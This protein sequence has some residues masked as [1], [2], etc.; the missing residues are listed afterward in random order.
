M[1]RRVLEFVQ[2]QMV[3]LR[4]EAERESG[5]V[6]ARKLGRE[7][8]GDIVKRETAGFAFES[9]VGFVEAG[10]QIVRGG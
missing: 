9:G 3:E 5:R 10:Q 1:Q 8:V 4:I 2:Q 6:A 7:L